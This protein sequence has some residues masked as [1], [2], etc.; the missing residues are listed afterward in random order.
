MQPKPGTLLARAWQA[1]DRL[2][3]R[4]QGT[5]ASSKGLQLRESVVIVNGADAGSSLQPGTAVAYLGNEGR[6]LRVQHQQRV[7]TVPRSSVV[8]VN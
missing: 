3:E 5:P 6:Y 2:I 8:R 1:G 4:V 7:L